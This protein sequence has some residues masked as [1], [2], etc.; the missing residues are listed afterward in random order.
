[1]VMDD[2]FATGASLCAALQLLEE[3][4]ID[5]R[6]VS[7]MVVAEFPVHRGREALRLRSFGRVHIQS[8]LVFGGASE[9]GGSNLASSMSFF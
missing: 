8:L 3:A 7:I 6:D 4:N 2:V 5:A 9:T 1:M